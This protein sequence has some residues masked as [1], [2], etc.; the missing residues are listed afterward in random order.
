MRLLMLSLAKWVRI[1]KANDAARLNQFLCPEEIIC[2]TR[3]S[4]AGI[5]E[6]E[7]RSLLAASEE[8]CRPG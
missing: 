4:V 3:R 6:D 5:N 1:V 2:H 7:I 8:F